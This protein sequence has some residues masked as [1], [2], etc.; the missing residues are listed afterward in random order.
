MDGTICASPS[1]QPLCLMIQR[2][3]GVQRGRALEG[4]SFRRDAHRRERVT[5]QE[6]PTSEG[7]LEHC[8]ADTFRRDAHRR[9][10]W[11][12]GKGTLQEGRT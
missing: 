7:E 1:S 12:I 11:D 2:G 5:L 10:S 8:R 4:R 6:G 9:G 3:I